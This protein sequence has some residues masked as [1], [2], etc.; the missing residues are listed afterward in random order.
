M[1]KRIAICQ[2]DVLL[3]RI[4]VQFIANRY[5]R[6]HVF[7]GGFRFQRG[8]IGAAFLFGFDRSGQIF[9]AKAGNRAADE[10]RHLLGDLDQAILPQL[11]SG[12][13]YGACRLHFFFESPCEGFAIAGD[14]SH[15]AIVHFLREFH[16]HAA[17]VIS[18]HAAAMRGH[19]FLKGIV[20]FLPIRLTGFAVMHRARKDNRLIAVCAKI[21]MLDEFFAAGNIFRSR[22]ANKQTLQ[23]FLLCLLISQRTERYRVLL[24]YVLF[25]LLVPF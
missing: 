1:G 24:L 18:K 13:R 19:G 9:I 2:N 3:Q 5:A 22:G 11:M 21:I 14:G 17:C 23:P 12:A 7:I 25:H 15:I 16:L 10:L 4:A 6:Q 8:D 20:D